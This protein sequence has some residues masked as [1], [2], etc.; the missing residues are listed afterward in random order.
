VALHHG[1]HVERELR[2]GVCCATRATFCAPCMQHQFPQH[3][4]P[5][6]PACTQVHTLEAMA[7]GAAGPEAACIR[8]KCDG[9]SSDAKVTI[10]KLT[11]L[12]NTLQRHL[13]SASKS[14]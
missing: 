5:V 9:A 2:V 6:S 7:E 11:W 4:Q 10:M 3:P 14:C 1:D 13:T 12:H 8:R